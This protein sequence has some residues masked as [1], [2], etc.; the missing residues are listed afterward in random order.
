MQAA[1]SLPHTASARPHRKSAPPERPSSRSS[2]PPRLRCTTPRPTHLVILHS[3]RTTT[4]AHTHVHDQPI[5]AHNPPLSNPILTPLLLHSFTLDLTRTPSNPVTPQPSPGQCHALSYQISA[6]TPCWGHPSSSVNNLEVFRTDALIVSLSSGRM[7]LRFTTCTANTSHLSDLLLCKLLRKLLC[8]ASSTFLHELHA[9]KTNLHANA[10]L[11]QFVRGL[12]NHHTQL[13]STPTILHL[14]LPTNYPQLKYTCQ[15][16]TKLPPTHQ[17]ILLQQIQVISKHIS[18]PARTF[19]AYPTIFENVTIVRSS[20][21]LMICTPP[22][23]QMLPPQISLPAPC[24]LS[25]SH[26][27]QRLNQPNS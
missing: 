21:S 7:D 20:P 22:S 4:A 15:R 24:P 25:L 19:K 27:N 3:P 9:I 17:D 1:P 6:P 14:Q 11:R 26:T 2:P 18:Y 5:R 10:F 12:H 16:L 23:H 8:H 13:L